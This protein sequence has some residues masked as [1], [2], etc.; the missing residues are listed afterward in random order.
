MV[1]HL[2]RY[3]HLYNKHL[4]EELEYGQQKERTDLQ[5]PLYRKLHTYISYYA[6]NEVEAHRKFHKLMFNSPHLLLAPYKG[7]FTTTKGLPCVHLLQQRLLEHRPLEIDD[8]D[9]QWRIDRLGE[10]AELPPVRKITDPLIV[11][12][13]LTKSQ[14]RQLSL[15]KVV[16]AQVTLL[17]L[18]Q[19]KKGKQRLRV[20]S[21]AL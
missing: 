10:L 15:F 6:I 7:L 11:R 4:R 19:P 9:V 21:Q 20:Q 16:Q 8:F 12:T 13:R 5:N 3:L 18:A 17:E 14:K 2:S 1:D